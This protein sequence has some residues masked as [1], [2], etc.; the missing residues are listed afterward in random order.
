MNRGIKRLLAAIAL[1]LVGFQSKSTTQTSQNFFLMQPILGAS[2]FMSMSDKKD[3][4]KEFYGSFHAMGIY[5]QNWNYNNASGLGALPFSNGT[6]SITV[7]SA[8]Q[9]TVDFDAFQLGL[10]QVGTS[11]VT[12]S[13]APSS[14]IRRS[15]CV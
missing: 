15:F 13:L 6:N 8:I 1:T 9:S 7:G 5:Q 10:G 4:D 2:T 14:K 3:E 12:F 11:T